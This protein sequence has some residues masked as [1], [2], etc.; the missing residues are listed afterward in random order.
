MT[1]ETCLQANM[2]WRHHEPMESWS[3]M[4]IVFEGFSPISLI[5]IL[6]TKRGLDNN[7]FFLMPS[8][9]WPWN[10]LAQAQNRLQWGRW[11]IFAAFGPVGVRQGQEQSK[12]HQSVGSFKGGMS[13]HPCSTQGDTAF[14]TEH[15]LHATL[16]SPPT[17]CIRP[18]M[19][20]WFTRWFPRAPSDT[21]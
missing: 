14:H 9:F 7:T 6:T 16:G 12:C 15:R 17:T 1:T 11:E 2:S 19:A 5:C 13:L 8:C 4:T 21:L 10:K 18:S 3:V 20:L